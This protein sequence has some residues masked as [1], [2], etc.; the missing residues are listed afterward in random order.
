M[1][2]PRYIF[3]VGG[4]ISGLGKGI[5]A[6]SIGRMLED[7]GFRV[8]NVKIDAY[9]NVDAG[10]M[11]PTEHGEVFVTRDG[12]ETDQDLGNYER[13]LGREL[14]GDNYAT[15]GQIYQSLIKKE[16]NLEFGG[17]CVEVVPHVP[18]EIIAKIDNAASKD[19]A[20]IVI[21][22]I[23][24]TVGEY[25]NI[26]F[27]EAARMLKYKNPDNVLIALVSFLPVPNTLGEMKTKPTQYASR[28]LNET[29]IQA[30][31]LIC[32]GSQKLDKPRTDRLSLLCNM[33]SK[34]DIF[35]APDVDNV[36]MVPLIFEKQGM[37]E[38]IIDKLKLNKSKCNFSKW[39]KMLKVALKKKKKIKIGIVGKYFSNGQFVL[40]DVYISVI[41]A[42]KHGGWANDVDVELDWVNAEEFEKDSKN[43]KKL[44]KYDGIVVPGGFGNRGI[45]GIIRA[46]KYA[47]ENKIPYLGLCYGMQLA[48]IE[49]A[50]NVAKIKDAC[51]GE[52]DEKGKNQVIHIM[53][54]QEKKMLKNDYGGTMRLGEYPAKLKKGSIS[55]RAYKK[56]K[57]KERHRH[58]FEFNN[59]YR[60]KLKKHGLVI[61]GTSPDDHIVE[62]IELTSDKHPF[63]VG[64]QFHPEFKSWPTKSH[65]LFTEFIKMAKT[66]TK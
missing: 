1:S 37:A 30:D 13:F 53:P 24:G 29:G 16:R 4:V 65:P 14:T 50:R 55:Y 32:R 34:K 63:F 22:E 57:I 61:A 3:V 25:Q 66:L 58:R 45:E 52:I 38:R 36:Y 23:G 26:L 59:K 28:T 17:K 21:V 19:K 43:V 18:Q 46:I 35:S 47:R 15:T 48:T 27:I 6:A 49:F 33:R 60:D 12:L 51:T 20:E 44:D 56:A 40:S 39:N 54:D 42:I 41:E 64:V 9:V 62:I 7:C 10:T 5:T 31:I 11:N 2:K 8:T